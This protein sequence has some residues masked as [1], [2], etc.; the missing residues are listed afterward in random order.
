MRYN[1]TRGQSEGTQRC[2][3]YTAPIFR[4]RYAHPYSNLQSTRYYSRIY[5]CY[6]R[7]R[8]DSKLASRS[9]LPFFFFALR[10]S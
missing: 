5:N 2:R 6:V 10:F 4:M 8:I 9:A 1:D 3:Q 7:R